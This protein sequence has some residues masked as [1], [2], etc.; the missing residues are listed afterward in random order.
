MPAASDLLSP[1]LV[2]VAPELPAY[3]REPLE[4]PADAYSP[5]REPDA[6]DRE[7]SS[8]AVPIA[9]GQAISEARKRLMEAGVESDV[10]G[11][12]VPRK[13]FRRRARLVPASA[14]ATSVALLV[15]QLYLSHGALP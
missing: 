7:P 3:P 14:A 5:L 13:H 2:L 9:H 12:L 15:L 8:D 4:V 1:E 11:S 10:L 6:P